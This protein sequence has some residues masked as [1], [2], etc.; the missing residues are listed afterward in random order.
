MAIGGERGGGLEENRGWARR[1]GQAG[2]CAVSVVATPTTRISRPVPVGT[3]RH[4]ARAGP[5]TFDKRRRNGK[6]RAARDLEGPLLSVT[7]RP[8]DTFV[9][10]IY[11]TT[12]LRLLDAAWIPASIPLH[13]KWIVPRS[14]GGG[15]VDLGP[16]KGERGRILFRRGEISPRNICPPFLRDYAAPRDI[17]SETTMERV[18]EFSD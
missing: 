5:D 8:T 6:Q 11:R 7:R 9:P 14:L 4:A 17:I 18:S 12:L 3:R 2:R 13:P 1:C 16:R 10:T 15:G